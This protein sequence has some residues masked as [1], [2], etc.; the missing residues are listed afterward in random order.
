MLALRTQQI[1]AYESGVIAEPDPLG[2][3]HHVESL[4]DKLEQQAREY[5]NK[6]DNMGGMLKGIESGLDKLVAILG[7]QTLPPQLTGSPEF[8]IP[9]IVKD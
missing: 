1:I 9:K 6:I 8:N 3:S 5:L 4:T 7:A 2:G